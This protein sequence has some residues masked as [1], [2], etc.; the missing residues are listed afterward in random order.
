MIND[1]KIDIQTQM[2]KKQLDQTRLE[3][4]EVKT[5]DFIT[6]I[7]INEVKQD[8]SDFNGKNLE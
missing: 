6:S 3:I 5:Y 2:L 8:K 7:E 1:N 4:E